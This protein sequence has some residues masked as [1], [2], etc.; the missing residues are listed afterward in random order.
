MPRFRTTV[1]A[2]I[3]FSDDLASEIRGY[4][5][6]AD[7]RDSLPA[8]FGRWHPLSQA[9]YLEAAYLLPSYILSS[10]GDRVAMAHA[11]EGRF[12]FLDH[13][14]VEFAARIPP[15]YKLRTLREKHILREAGQG[16]LPPAVGDRTK[17]PYRATEA[18]AFT[19][20]SSPTETAENFSG[21]EIRRAGYFN[22][23]A[24]ERLWNKCRKQASIGAR[25]NMALIG[26][27]SAQLWHQQFVQR[28]ASVQAI[29]D[30]H[31]IA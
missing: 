5:A 9:Q 14:L 26:V 28:N 30:L 19:S 16:L 23:Q 25:D 4:D 18:E 13:R 20:A 2:K 6:L 12:P 22:P 27:L 10:Q 29:A 31:A 8:E 15:K 11:V 17:Q 1:G 3:F 24:V 21:S 7:L